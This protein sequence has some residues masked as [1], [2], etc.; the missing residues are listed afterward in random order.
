MKQ[1]IVTK[2][3]TI[4]PSDKDILKENGIILIEC[5]NPNEVRVINQIEGFEADD[6]VGA[7]IETIKSTVHS[8]VR[9]EF[10]KKLLDRAKK[11]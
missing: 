1:I 7:M 11:K 10:A 6:F 2:K 9:D 5:E 3:D 4:S 8:S